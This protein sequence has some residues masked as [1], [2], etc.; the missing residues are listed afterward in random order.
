MAVVRWYI[1]RNQQ[2]I[3][4]FDTAQLRQLAECGVVQPGEHVLVE[5]GTKW[6]EARTVPGLFPSEA[7]TRYWLSVAG[8][9]RGPYVAEQI[10]AGLTTRR[11]TMDTQVYSEKTKKWAPLRQVSEFQEDAP[12]TISRSQAQLLA[13]TLDLEEARLHLAGKEGDTAASLMSMLMDLK[14]IHEHNPPLVEALDRSLDLLKVQ[15]QKPPA[16]PQQQPQAKPPQG[17]GTK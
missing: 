17:S 10:Q 5:G 6:V 8:Q 4:P 12:G 7:H 3:G 13:G 9:T 1:A 11:L 16:A 15:R 2:K 14:R